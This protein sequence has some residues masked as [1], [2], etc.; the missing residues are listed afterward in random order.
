MLVTVMGS[1]F[2][3]AMCISL[4]LCMYVCIFQWRSKVLVFSIS[5]CVVS[6]MMCCDIEGCE[7]ICVI[8]S[9]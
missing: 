8:S 5:L 4:N 6:F 2:R 3:R 7:I 1:E 9:A